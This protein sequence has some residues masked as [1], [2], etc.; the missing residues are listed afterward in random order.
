MDESTLDIDIITPLPDLRSISPD[1]VWWH[2]DEALAQVWR[3][4]AAEADLQDD[5]SVVAPFTSAL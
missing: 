2:G 3:E 5:Q 1:T 4:L